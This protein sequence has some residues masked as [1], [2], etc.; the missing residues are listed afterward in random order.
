MPYVRNTCL[1]LIPFDACGIYRITNKIDGKFYIGSAA[2]MRRRL[3]AHLGSLRRGDHKNPHLQRAFIR[4][5]EDSFVMDVLLLCGKE[6]L[7]QREQEFLDLTKCHDDTIGYNISPRADAGPIRIYTDE[8]RA[9][10]SARFK[11]KSK[12]EEHRKRIS[13]GQKHRKPTDE[14]RARISK[15]LKEFFSDPAN[16]EAQSKRQTGL[17]R[18]GTP[19]TEE[20]K[21]KLSEARR[22]IGKPET[23]KYSV[24]QIRGWIEMR[25]RGISWFAMS[26]E[27]K[28]N[29]AVMKMSVD[30]YLKEN[31][32]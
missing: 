19:C 26:L 11:G 30:R 5:G 18:R 10:I 31:P 15:K 27:T 6:E 21:R 14:M 12:S 29:P 23:R 28:V 16:R 2:Q 4:D 22:G 13:E 1:K 7:L 17:K 9:E 8:M 24:D 3:R 25:A 32:A 20:M